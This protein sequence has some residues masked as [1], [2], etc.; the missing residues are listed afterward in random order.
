MRKVVQPKNKLGPLEGAS[1][2][3]GSKF[4]I[5]GYE[6]VDKVAKVCI[7]QFLF[8]LIAFLVKFP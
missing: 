4:I 2:I 3:F 7:D 6:Y 1:L 5:S 8:A